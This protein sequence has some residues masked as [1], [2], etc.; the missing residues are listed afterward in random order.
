VLAP[1]S[2]REAAGLRV[3]Y[4]FSAQSADAS[5]FVPR[6]DIAVIPGQGQ[7]QGRQDVLGE[8]NPYY[9]PRN[10]RVHS[11]LVTARLHPNSRVTL[12]A[13]GR[14]GLSAR[15]EAPMLT[16]VFTPPN[17][18]VARTFVERSFTPWNARGSLDVAATPAVRIALAVERGHEAYYSFTTARVQ[19]TYTFIAAAL[20]RADVH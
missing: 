1:L 19:L 17:V 8:Y 12:D 3:G 2:R 16:A 6:D 11:A 10:L 5:R 18:T 15:D 9:T 13:S 14:V 20:A 4:G 7:G